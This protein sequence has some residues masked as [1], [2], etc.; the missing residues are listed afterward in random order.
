MRDGVKKVIECVRHTR[1][2]KDKDQPTITMEQSHLPLTTQII[3]TAYVVRSVGPTLFFLY[4]KAACLLP[5]CQYLKLYE[6]AEKVGYHDNVYFGQMFKKNTNISP[7][8][9]KR[10]R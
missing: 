7:M 8:D 3:M 10:K 1:K 9:Y 2:S 5:C 6:I 4:S